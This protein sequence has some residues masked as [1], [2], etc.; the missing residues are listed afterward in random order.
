VTQYVDLTFPRPLH[1]YFTYSVPEE[2]AARL[3]PGVRVRAPFGRV[4][5]VGYCVE[6]HTR[7][8]SFETKPIIA[9]L[10]EAPLLDEQL[11]ALARWISREYLAPLGE[12][13][14]AMLPAGVRKNAKPRKNRLAE[15]SIGTQECLA[16]LEKLGERSPKQRIVLE[17]LMEA[18]RPLPVAE[19][20]KLA[21]TGVSAVTALERKGY[22]RIR[23]TTP[24]ESMFAVSREKP[25]LPE[26]LTPEQEAAL[27]TI[28]ESVEESRHATVLLHGITGSG[29]TEVYLR[30]IER[31]LGLGKSVLYLV[32]EIALTPQSVRRLKS[33]FDG[34]AV[35]HSQL[36]DGERN[37]AWR[38][39]RSGDCRIALGA[40]SAVF[41]PVRNLGLVVI[42]EEHESTFKQEEP[43]PRY[44]ARDV[45]AERAR[46]AEATLILGSASPSLETYHA[47]VGGRFRLATLPYR[48]ERRP[49]PPVRVVD[50]RY[51]KDHVRYGSNVSRELAVCIDEALAHREQVL[52]FM[53]RRG[54]ASTVH[55]VRCG[56]TFTC[57]HCAVPMTYHKQTEKLLCH[58]CRFSRPRPD[59][60][61][62]CLATN[63]SY[64]GRGT[65]RIEQDIVRRFPEARV[66]RIDSDAASKRDYYELTLEEFR[67]RRIDVLVGTQVI[68]KGLDFPN[69]TLVGVILADVALS[70]PDFRAG[71]RTFQLLSQVAGR[72]GRGP[73]GG[74]VV[75]QT[76]NPDSA[77]VEAARTH[78]YARF[79][80]DELA[81]R[82][83]HGYP[84]YKRVVQIVASAE[85]ETAAAKALG[86]LA[87][88]LRGDLGDEQGVQIL[89]PVP[90]PFP[91]LVGR[92]RFHVLIK[93][94][95]DFPIQVR[96]RP[97]VGKLRTGG[98]TVTV[99][100]D[101]QSI[102]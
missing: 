61:P 28:L 3:S 17:A 25:E 83:L 94:P 42:D 59:A 2:L 57:D 30:A 88:R 86:R 63:L 39:V 98:A 11:Q 24:G 78:D 81:E 91:R 58:Y 80:E 36:S 72:A 44:H 47:A 27:A 9:V 60:C 51:D 18:D 20:A 13:F 100:V 37:A 50:L 5:L 1:Q 67:S 48:I 29:K 31:V 73:K 34:V 69:V 22:V 89:G 84:P 46:A 85:K 15:L 66:A 70:L 62:E 21:E 93:C 19:V 32:P 97:L 87:D 74:R 7:E 54:F 55:C 26:R 49:L 8:P 71:E 40:R 90:A 68:A 35:F 12:V 16:A 23:E 14:E 52:L 43:A 10:D 101:P 95:T 76:Y 102:L 75:I 33:R 79:A 56:H 38:S 96:L 41:A 82:K 92:Y 45:A 64:R 6:A 53:N 77:P 99:D 4:T 65:Q